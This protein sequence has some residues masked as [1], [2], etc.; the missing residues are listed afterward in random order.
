MQDYFDSGNGA[1][2]DGDTAMAT[3]GGAVQAAGNGGDQMEDEVM[4]SADRW[5]GERAWQGGLTNLFSKRESQAPRACWAILNCDTS[6]AGSGGSM[7]G[8]SRRRELFLRGVLK[9][10]CGR[11]LDGQTAFSSGLAAFLFGAV[12]GCWARGDLAGPSPS[13]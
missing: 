7:T 12:A 1:G 8:V 6:Q 4:V 11:A 2:A 9:H 13:N 5:L 3:N 10:K